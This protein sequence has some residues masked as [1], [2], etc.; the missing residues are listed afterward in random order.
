[1]NAVLALR[2]CTPDGTC[3]YEFNKQPMRRGD[4]LALEG[5][6]FKM[7]LSMDIGGK[8]VANHWLTGRLEI[9]FE[10]YD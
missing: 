1:M 9:E 3:L 8:P 7:L 4:I 10:G 5:V 6:E 2:L